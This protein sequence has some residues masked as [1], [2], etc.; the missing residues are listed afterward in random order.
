M[1]TLYQ[2][3]SAS[4]DESGTVEYIQFVLTAITGT[5]YDANNAGGGAGSDSGESS[6][7]SGP[8]AYKFVLPSDYSSNSSNS[9]KGNGVFDNSRIVHETLGKIQLIPPF[10][11]QTSP[12]PFIV[13]IF[14]DES[15]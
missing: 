3:Q 1:Q 13:K 14:E 6:Q 10:F 11:S 5:T 15:V 8:H 12:N 7:S 2:I 4:A 9:K